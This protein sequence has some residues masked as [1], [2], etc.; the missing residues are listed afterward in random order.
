[1]KALTVMQPWASLIVR[2]IKQREFR[3]WAPAFRG[4]LAI[5]AGRQAPSEEAVAA[6]WRW[7]LRLAG[8]GAPTLDQVRQWSAG[9]PRGLVLGTAEL[10]RVDPVQSRWGRRA[11]ILANAQEFDRPLWALGQRG[12]WE[13]NASA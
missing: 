4:L 5:H 12:L 1:M 3:N 8:P 7:C 10:V 2:G 6:L 9:Q 11:W 13:W